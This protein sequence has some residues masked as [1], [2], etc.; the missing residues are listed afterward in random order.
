M[1]LIALRTAKVNL[2]SL[3]TL[4][5]G[6]K[7]TVMIMDMLL[8]QF[9]LNILELLQYDQRSLLLIRFAFICQIILAQTNM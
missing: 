3:Q 8:T 9:Y 5:S 2:Y 7:I 1:L 4:W 6:F